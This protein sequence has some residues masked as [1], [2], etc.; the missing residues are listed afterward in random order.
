MISFKTKLTIRRTQSI[1]IL[2]ENYIVVFPNMMLKV[3][4]LK[5]LE[6]LDDFLMFIMMDILWFLSVSYLDLHHVQI[7]KSTTMHEI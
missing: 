3:T 6:S 2:C 7:N 4:G 1:A 5:L